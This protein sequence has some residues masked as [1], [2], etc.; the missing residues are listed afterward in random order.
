[1]WSSLL[2]IQSVFHP[3]RAENIWRSFKIHLHG[4]AF[5]DTDAG[6]WNQSSEGTETCTANIIAAYTLTCWTFWNEWCH[7]PEVIW[8]VV[9]ILWLIQL[10][11]LSL[12]LLENV[13]YSNLWQFVKS[14]LT[15]PAWNSI[16]AH[17]NSIS[18][19]IILGAVANANAPPH[20]ICTAL[21]QSTS[22]GR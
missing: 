5:L 2:F 10:K 16:N 18:V 21:R 11:H 19:S 17:T 15:F 7:S 8:I 13:K 12:R 1:M 20:K 6:S 3:R 22:I 4:A 9:W 14:K